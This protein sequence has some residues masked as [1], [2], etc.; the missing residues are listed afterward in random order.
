MDATTT[1]VMGEN[2]WKKK[3]REKPVLTPGVRWA[4]GGNL[5]TMIRVF[6]E[7]VRV[8]VRVRVRVTDVCV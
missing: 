8:R 3:K 1:M 7:E 4:P 5:S 6:M 2:T